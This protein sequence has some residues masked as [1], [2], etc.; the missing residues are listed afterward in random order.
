MQHTLLNTVYSSEE[1]RRKGHQ[2]ID[3]LAD[4]L[5][6]TIHK[7]SPKVINWNLPEDEKAH[8]LT[9]LKEGEVAD[10]FPEILRHT[11]HVHHPKYI[12]HQVCAPAP[13]ASLAALVSS[14][15]NNGMAVYEMGMA[16]TAIERIITTDPTTI[17]FM[18]NVSI[19]KSFIKFSAWRCEISMKSMNVKRSIGAI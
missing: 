17:Y 10:F 12:G 14:M 19:R 15:L 6:G 13:I 9:F 8:W 11:T 3:Q 16:P 1:F 2:L 18:L 5:K 4:H 7:T